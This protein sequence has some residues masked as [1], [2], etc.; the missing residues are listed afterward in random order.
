MR[1]ILG[2]H[3]TTLSLWRQGK[4]KGHKV[5]VEK[6]IEEWLQN[7]YANK[8]R[9]SN[10]YSTRFQEIKNNEILKSQLEEK[11]THVLM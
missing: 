3:H 11:G 2:I 10:L 5:G 9:F 4:V 1:V 8:P 7:L 6:I